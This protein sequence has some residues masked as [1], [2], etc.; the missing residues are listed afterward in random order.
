MYCLKC[1]RD[2]VDGH[3]FCL[4]C[5]EAMVAHPV[6]PGT[7]VNLPQR[8]A[9]SAKKPTYRKRVIPPDEQIAA[10]RKSLRRT[11]I[12]AFILAI[13]LLMAGALLVHEFNDLDVPVI[14]QNYTIHIE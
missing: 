13:I 4:A 5:Q 9:S 14:G 7:P 2:T 12:L 1:G 6:K 8:K 10:L 3:V 11:R